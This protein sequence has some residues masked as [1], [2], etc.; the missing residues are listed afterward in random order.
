MIHC[1]GTVLA[2]RASSFAARDAK[3]VSAKVRPCLE[4]RNGGLNPQK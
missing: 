1:R 4:D 3:E 2:L